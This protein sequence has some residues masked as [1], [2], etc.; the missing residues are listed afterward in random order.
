MVTPSP[1]PKTDTRKPVVPPPLINYNIK[2][3]PVRVIAPKIGEDGEVGEEMLG[4]YSLDEALEKAD[5]MELDLVMINEKADP[6]VCK[7]IDYGKFKYSMEKKK[8]ENMK[9]QVKGGLKEVKM[10]YKIDVHDFDVR[11]KA[12]LRFIAA[13]DRVSTLSVYYIQ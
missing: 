3:D 7:I 11:V 2:A 8:K 10:S 13:G 9:K 1:R 12:A 4:I 6:P 5:S